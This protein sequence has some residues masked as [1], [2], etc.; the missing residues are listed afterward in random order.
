MLNIFKVFPKHYELFNDFIIS[1]KSKS[2]KNVNIC[3]LAFFLVKIDPYLT[4]SQKEQIFASW[5]VSKGNSV[6]CKFLSPG[7]NTVV[8]K[9]VAFIEHFEN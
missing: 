7:Y 1:R 4:F 5:D 6:F 8:K 9:F 2:K 3:L